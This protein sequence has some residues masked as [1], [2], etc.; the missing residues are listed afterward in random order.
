MSKQK[1]KTV[2]KSITQEE[3]DQIVLPEEAE[4]MHL[5]E[6][7]EAEK[8]AKAAKKA[9]KEEAKEEIEEKIEAKAEENVEEGKTPKKAR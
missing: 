6:L 4:K 8:K 1:A 7:K 2:D 5:K 3:L 9:A